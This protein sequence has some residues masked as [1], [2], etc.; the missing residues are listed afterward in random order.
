MTGGV[1]GGI[2][3]LLVAVCVAA[4]AWFVYRTP[5][6]VSVG[7]P[8]VV[9][10]IP[11]GGD[12]VLVTVEPGEGAKQVGARLQEAGIVRS[13]R[14][15]EIL[16]SLRGVGDRL[17][18]GE[19]EFERG[20]PALVAVNRIAEGR[21]AARSVVF[22]E[23]MRVEEMAEALERAGVVPK[24]EFLAALDRTRYDQPFLAEVQSTDLQGFLFPARYEFKRNETGDA[25]VG[26]MLQAF[27]DNVA[28]G[29]ERE[30]QNLTLQELV[31]LGS[32]VQREAGNDEEMPIIAGIFRN[33]LRL[34][35]PLQA[36]PTVQYAVAADPAAVA[37]FGWW[38][39]ELTLDDLALDSP[40]NT[41]LY[42]GLPPG[43]IANPGLQA[44]RAVVSPA[45]TNFLFF[46][47]KNDGTHVFAETLE[48][49]LRNVEQYQ[50]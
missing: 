5:G 1:R 49:H 23:G 21:T 50:R 6:S 40:Y 2:A 43:A 11:T 36:D 16:V 20:T 12:P 28:D 4:T 34:G 30:G 46:V 45:Q 35:M 22:P 8:P 32:I 39:R 14:L 41:Y 48:E 18:A 37:E 26:R 31:T 42:P 33:R 3:V 15:F 17:A 19:Y 7:E 25:V 38:K 24:N 10:P 13:A 27:Q 44:M 9:E 29:L 47:S